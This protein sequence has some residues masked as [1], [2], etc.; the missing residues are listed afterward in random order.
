MRKN[1]RKGPGILVI[2]LTAIIS[3]T[4]LN[5]GLSWGKSY[6]SKEVSLYVG[7]PPGGTL[8]ISGRV[9]AKVL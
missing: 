8:D 1:W 9:I 7:A 2:A 3:L 4:F 6:P 5:P